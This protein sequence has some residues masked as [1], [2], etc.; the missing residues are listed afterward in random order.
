MARQSEPPTIRKSL[1]PI[2]GKASF[3]SPTILHWFST[4]SPLF[5]LAIRKGRTPSGFPGSKWVE[6]YGD[7][8]AG[9]TAIAARAGAEVQKA[10]GRVVWLDPEHGTYGE[11]LTRVGMDITDEEKFIIGHPFSLESCCAAIEHVVKDFA[12]VPTLIVIDSLSSLGVA[13]YSMDETNTK[14]T[15]P[16]AAAAKKLHEWWRRGVLYYMSHQPVYGIM[17]RHKTDSPAGIW[18]GGGGDHTTHGKSL[19]YYAWLR[20]KMKRQDLSAGEGGKLLGSWLTARV[21]KSKVGPIHGECSFPYYYDSGFD[22]G[23]EQICYLVDQGVLETG[24][25]SDGSSTGRIAYNGK[26]YLIRDLRANYR[27]N[28]NFRQDIDRKV[29]ETY[30]ANL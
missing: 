29:L 23:L 12:D 5:D 10:G 13:D 28:L 17:I 7:E 14:K 21:I 6:L 25:K 27:D 11:H 16:S 15:P 30:H 24:K 1:E 9:K 26:N 4:G 3:D 18:Q 2:L 22:V 8:S 20:I 19:N